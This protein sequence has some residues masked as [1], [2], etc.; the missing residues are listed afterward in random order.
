MA[1]MVSLN[2]RNDEVIEK[3]ETCC[4]FNSIRPWDEEAMDPESFNIGVVILEPNKT[5]LFKL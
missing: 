3:I 2:L 4:V 1:Q 5:V